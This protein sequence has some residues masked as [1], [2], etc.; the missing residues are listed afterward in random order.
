MIKS[1]NHV[2]DYWKVRMRS[3]AGLT[4]GSLS[5]AA[6]AALPTFSSHCLVSSL[7]LL[8]T[9]V[10]GFIRRPTSVSAAVS[11]SCSPSS[12]I[13]FWSTPKLLRYQLALR[14]P[15]SPPCKASR[16]APSC[17]STAL[18]SIKFPP[19]WLTTSAKSC[20]RFCRSSGGGA[21]PPSI[22]ESSLRV[23]GNRPPAPLPP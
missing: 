2:A 16:S 19:V 8:G 18:I 17:C 22:G 6:L 12:S 5:R 7:T 15:P 14:C 4:V 9:R 23:P 3:P 1:W 20:S 21:S 13:S 11:V 10:R